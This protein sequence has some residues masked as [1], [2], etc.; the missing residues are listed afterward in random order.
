[1][2]LY[3]LRLFR[4]ITQKIKKFKIRIKSQLNGLESIVY[5]M[6]VITQGAEDAPSI[7]DVAV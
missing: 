7:D 4:K 5:D 1:M 3:R 2:Q 6:T